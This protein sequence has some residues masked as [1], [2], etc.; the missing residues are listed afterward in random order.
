M[1]SEQKE[2]GP[3]EMNRYQDFFNSNK[4]GFCEKNADGI[5]I[6]QNKICNS[7]CG[8]QKG[9]KCNSGCMLD[10]SKANSID[11]YGFSLHRDI[12]KGTKT[13]VD[14]VILRSP[15]NIYTF[16]FEKTHFIDKAM[17]QLKEYGLTKT[18]EL[19]TRLILAGNLNT[20]IANLMFVS[21]KTIHTHLNNI[22]KK[23]PD[24]LKLV[25]SRK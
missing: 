1:F 10:N 11:A 2:R 22:Y 4:I 12:F 15:Q 9:I 20:D 18:E 19:I 6:F 5:V 3:F 17:L 13:H 21:K 16:L 8:L 7:I 23:I 25:S 24:K 14:G